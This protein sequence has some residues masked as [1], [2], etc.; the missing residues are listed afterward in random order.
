MGNLAA[1]NADHFF[2]CKL[3]PVVTHVWYITTMMPKN[4]NRQNISHFTFYLSFDHCFMGMDINRFWNVCCKYCQC[5]IYFH[6]KHE[7]VRFSVATLCGVVKLPNYIHV[8]VNI[9]PQN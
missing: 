3:N 9:K 4:L 6:S 5:M 1:A 2:G 7:Q 8:T